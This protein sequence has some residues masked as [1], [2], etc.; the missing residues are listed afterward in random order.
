MATSKPVLILVTPVFPKLSETF[1]LSKFMGLIRRGWQVHI[2]CSS[3][4][5]DEWVNF[6]DF[7]RSHL[8][9]R[10]HV[11]WPHHPRWLAA[12]LMPLSWLRCLLQAPHASIRYLHQGWRRFGADILR[13]GYLDAELIILKPDII[14]FEFGTLGIG[15]TYIKE[16]LGCKLSVSFRGYDLNFSGLDDHNYYQEIWKRVNAI[17]LLGEDLWQRAQKR[18][19]PIDKPHIL[20]PPSID[21]DFFRLREKNQNQILLGTIENPFRVLSVGR[22]EW[23]KGYEFSLQAV[24]QLIEQGIHC[25]YRIVG[26]GDFMDAV[27]FTIH[28]L[29]LETNVELMGSMTPLEVHQQ[30]L[31]GHVLLHLA[32]SEGFCNAVLEAQAMQ[33]P[34]VCSDADGLRENIS[35]G[36]SG[37]VVK[38]RD[39]IGAADKLHFLVN[40]PA[41]RKKMG[42]AGRARVLNFF[43]INNQ[44]SSFEKFYFQLLEKAD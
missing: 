27:A 1:I 35:D 11:T 26:S 34:V 41:L 7:D 38:R 15:R 31:W 28:Q 8:K 22:I 40:N 10:I 21:T 39:P 13:R 25:Q 17:H 42:Q 37:F 30:M 33:L 4:P 2:V 5:R 24:K 20:I 16:L 23:K 29:G 43:Q 44:I 12:L 6:S 3:S 18:G 32:V 14:H 19:C 9:N 36:E